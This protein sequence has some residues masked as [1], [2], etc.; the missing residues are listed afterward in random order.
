MPYITRHRREEIDKGGTPENAGELNYVI[1]TTIIKYLHE[2][3]CGQP[4]TYADYNE[5]I[6]VLECAKLEL[7]RRIVV[8][9]ENKKKRLN[10]DVI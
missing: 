6:G 2:L 5:I 8:P 7:F 1:T 3:T 9:Y 10:G 4:N